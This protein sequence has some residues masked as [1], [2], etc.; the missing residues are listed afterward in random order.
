MISATSPDTPL[1]R[2]AAW[3]V[4][5]GLS[6]VDVLIIGGGVNGV[7]TLRDL[8]LNGVTAV[9][10]EQGDFCSGASGASSRMAHGG[11]RYLEGREFRLVAEA[12]RE[13]NALLHDAPH[14]VRPLQI[15]VPLEHRLRGL[16]GAILRFS[17]LSKRPGPLSL[18]ALKG[19]LTFYERFGAVRR[20]LP[21]HSAWGRN[22]AVTKGMPDGVKAVVTYFDGQ[23]LCPEGLV[24][25]MLGEAMTQ[26]GVTAL[27]H[28]AW[29]PDGAG[30]IVITDTIQGGRQAVVHPRVIVNA[31]GAAIDRVN[32]RLGIAGTLIRGVK[33]AH[34]LLRNAL[35]Q[36]RMNGRAYYFD[37]GTGRMV[38]CLPVGDCILMGTT[39]VET[40]DPDDRNV[41]GAEIGYLLA[42]LT[43]LFADIRPTR[44]QIIA[45]TTGIR[46]LQAGDGSATQAAR[47][48]A[49]VEARHGTVPVLS[50]VGGKWTTFRSFAEQAADVA[51]TR[52]GRRRNLSTAG[53][54][55]PG[56]AALD[57]AT[58]AARLGT[59]EARIA[60]LIVRYG[61][62]A[63]AVAVEEAAGPM[64]A[65]PGQPD[66]SEAEIAW[67]VRNRMACRLEDLVLRRTGLVTT[68]CLTAETLRAC[69]A[70]MARKLGRDESWIEA[71][72]ATVLRD[73]RILG[74][75][76][77]TRA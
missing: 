13:R 53:R 59:S 2:D 31:A 22:A 68:G 35:L 46:P 50:L 10:V 33:G 16:G 55:Y 18:V 69:A 27:N 5:G 3:S 12:A 6:Q 21:R 19:A 62:L 56:A 70:V 28:V 4:L 39:E 9:L 1:A 54:P 74:L 24:M 58:L 65:L 51:L 75:Q 11:L 41:E 73:P 60:T 76:V 57:A 45:V 37:D 32:A 66:Y 7:A 63:A 25:E 61:A 64:V 38:I 48:H 34:L 49:L 26:S 42:A 44:D 15:V 30:G 47:D 40:A 71:E 8:A 23:I 72:L 20:A 43:R 29:A 52:L 77:V 14:A 67:L 17:G 36:R